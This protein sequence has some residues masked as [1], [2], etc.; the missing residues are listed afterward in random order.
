MQLDSRHVART[1]KWRLSAHSCDF[2]SPAWSLL[3]SSGGKI[4]PT[5]QPR[6]ASLCFSAQQLSPGSL[7]PP[8]AGKR[9]AMLSLQRTSEA[10]QRRGR[11]SFSLALH[12]TT[13]TKERGWSF[14]S[15][16][17]S[18]QKFFCCYCLK[19]SLWDWRDR[20]NWIVWS[21]TTLELRITTK[22]WLT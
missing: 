12:S 1:R 21:F 9:A 11:P 22:A 15:S 18:R 3:R 8:E 19:I 7:L 10:A 4:L 5:Q 20:T 17:A 6:W 16:F 2:P 13:N 14:L